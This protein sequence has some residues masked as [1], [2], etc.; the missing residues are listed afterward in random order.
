M[1]QVLVLVEGQT[2]ET[3]VKR[4]LAP[5]LA[6][7]QIWITPIIVTTHGANKGGLS[8]YSIVKKELCNLRRDPHIWLTTMFDFYG[9]PR[10]FPGYKDATYPSVELG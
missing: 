4:V 9:L 7:R 2:E 10:D 6:T 1:T 8:R 5:H 3:F